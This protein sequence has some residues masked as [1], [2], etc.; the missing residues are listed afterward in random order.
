MPGAHDNRREADE[1]PSRTELVVVDL[2]LVAYREALELQR[3]VARRGISGDIDH[4]VLLLVQHPHVITLGRSYKGKTLVASPELLRARGVEVV[5]VDRGGDITYHGPGQLVGYPIF[6]L[7]RHT[8]DLHWYLR[9]VE[10][11]LIVAL[12]ALGI[13]ATR[14]QGLTGVWVSEAIE[15]S[16]E[17]PTS[18]AGPG[19]VAAS[20]S[21]GPRKIA[22]IGVHARD[23][24]TWHGFALNVTTDLSYFDLMVPCGISDVQ[25]TSVATE[26]PDAR[27]DVPAVGQVVA[28]A[29]AA[30][31]HGKSGPVTL[32]RDFSALGSSHSASGDDANAAHGAFS[33]PP[34]PGSTP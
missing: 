8:R 19:P 9:Q 1:S 7:K 26:R 29:F 2:G 24:V 14:R 34:P 30:V 23:W 5:E 10:Q 3:D 16:E 21:G 27:L 11:A 12:G 28:D 33:A 31:F 18:G 13:G 4:D 32:H 22:S 17:M 15:A 25:M 20:P 6:D